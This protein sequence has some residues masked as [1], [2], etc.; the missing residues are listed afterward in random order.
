MKSI[1]IYYL[2]FILFVSLFHFSCEKEKVNVAE[3]DNEKDFSTL[4][5]I[6]LDNQ[7]LLGNDA[8]LLI[9]NKKGEILFKQYYG[10]W[11]DSTYIPIASAS[12]LPSMAV[13]MSLVEKNK[14]QLDDKI[15]VY[16]PVAFSGSDRKDILVK[17]LMNHTS[18]LSPV[19][20]WVGSNNVDLQEA[21]EGIGQGGTVANKALMS[22]ASS[23]SKFA[24]GGVSMHVAGG[25][26]EKVSQKKWNELFEEKIASPCQMTNTDY[27][28]VGGTSEN[29]RIAGGMGTTLPDYANFLLMLINEGKFNSRQVLTAASVNELL[30][31]QTQNIPIVSTPYEGDALRQNFEYGYGCWIE[32]ETNGIATAF[33]SQGAFG[34]SPWIDKKREIIGIVFVQTSFSNV[35]KNPTV[36]NAPYTLIK[37][38]VNEIMDSE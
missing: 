21:V 9:M 11:N 27:L 13:L 35:N 2:A 18:G 5:Q 23:G 32:E 14:I 37:R 4:N 10:S 19:S 31:N 26:A 33:G 25:I 38:K 12:K 34:F 20:A 1:R 15:S 30:S 17:Q 7:T 29:Y 16:Y 8:G 22:Y 36:E 3:E 24:Y 6:M 28:G